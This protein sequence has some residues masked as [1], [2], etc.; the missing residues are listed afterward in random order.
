[1]YESD[2]EII[3]TIIGNRWS[4]YLEN[5]WIG[6]PNGI[7]LLKY[8]NKNLY[9]DLNLARTEYMVALRSFADGN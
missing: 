2:I 7:S 6:D 4:V 5:N 9:V 8:V 1:M 3:F